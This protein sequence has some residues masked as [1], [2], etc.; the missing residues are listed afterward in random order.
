[1][2]TTATVS[3]HSNVYHC[4]IKLEEEDWVITELQRITDPDAACVSLT[5]RQ[6]FN[7]LIEFILGGYCSSGVESV[8]EDVRFTATVG[9]LTQLLHQVKGA[10]PCNPFLPH[11]TPQLVDMSPLGSANN[12]MLTLK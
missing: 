6:L 10:L 9:Y 5:T 4:L 8:L 11:H 3:S 1:M 12:W 2:K 7:E